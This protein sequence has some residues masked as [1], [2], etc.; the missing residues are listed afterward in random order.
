MRTLSLSEAKMKLSE[1]VE[2]VFSTDEEVMITKNGRPSAVL[3]SPDEFEFAS[4][5]DSLREPL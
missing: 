4:S 2:K 5:T 3:V 1:L